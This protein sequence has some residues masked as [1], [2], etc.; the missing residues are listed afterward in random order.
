MRVGVMGGYL[1]PLCDKAYDSV[2][3]LFAIAKSIL[4]IITFIIIL[5]KISLVKYHVYHVMTT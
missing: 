3:G 2:F 4:K 1:I 5:I